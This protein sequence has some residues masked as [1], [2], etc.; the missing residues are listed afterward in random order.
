MFYMKFVLRLSTMNFATLCRRINIK[1]LVT[2]V[3]LYGGVSGKTHYSVFNGF[4]FDVV[5][6]WVQ[7]P[8]S[9]NA[10]AFQMHREVE[11]WA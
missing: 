9:V 6:Y 11:V 10:N 5:W 7:S 1:E 8:S 4:Y 2:S 3:P